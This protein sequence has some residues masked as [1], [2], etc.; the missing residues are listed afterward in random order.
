METK[1]CRKCGEV[2]AV[3]AFRLN[4]KACKK[5]NKRTPSQLYHKKFDMA[6][7]RHRK[8][9][10]GGNMRGRDFRV[11]WERS[12]GCFYC[13]SKESLEFDHFIPK[14]LG[15]TNDIDNV[16][17]AC[18]ECNSKKSVHPPYPPENWA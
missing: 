8:R 1:E 3:S 12:S 5:C 9:F 7:Y 10:G 6:A 18:R 11:L 15:G 4:G 17:I 2:K 13:N 16:V 14:A